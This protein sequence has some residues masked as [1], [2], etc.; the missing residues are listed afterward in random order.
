[1]CCHFGDVNSC[2]SSNGRRVSRGTSGVLT[3]RLIY[4]AFRLAFNWTSS[5]TMTLTLAASWLHLGPLTS[6]C[7]Q[8]CKSLRRQCLLYMSRT[9]Y[10]S[11]LIANEFSM[12]SD[13]KIQGTDLGLD[14][15]D[16]AV[17]ALSPKASA[18]SPS[19]APYSV[20][21]QTQKRWIIA[22][23]ALAGWFSSL[24]SF[25]YFPAI[26]SIATD[27]GESIERINLTVTAYLIMSGLF[28]SIVADAADTM[29]R[30]PVFIVT[31][32]VYVAANIG[33]ALQTS[34]GLLF[35]LR[36]AQSA[37]ISGSYAVTYGVIGDVFTPSERGG[38]SGLVSFA[39]NTPPSI[40]PVISGLLLHRWGWRAIFWFL[41]AISP[42]C[43]LAIVFLLPETSR[44]IVDDGTVPPH[45]L[46]L[47][48]RPILPFLTPPLAR[49]SL[50]LRRA[51]AATRLP[52]RFR[53]PNP[54]TALIL[55]KAPGT[56][57]VIGSAGIWYTI[58][59]CL[60]ASLSSLF[61]E[62]Y[63]VSGLI[64]GVSYLPFGIACAIS[65]YCSG[66]HE[67]TLLS[68]L[69]LLTS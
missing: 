6:S 36:M 47:L 1:M 53:I 59:S 32:A 17:V 4:A 12:A 49:Q 56:A 64:S 29:G 33:L 35:F 65:A 9:P 55:L 69:S 28:P 16:K 13:E 14:P 31:L 68:K 5:C 57:I 66:R 27:L 24:S 26:P 45:G 41:S 60:Q 39:L 25:I 50:D 51:V 58:Y 21:T 10:C 40:G 43:L 48:S 30:R 42:C 18:S 34:F 7:P 15:A 67:F 37:G 61:T 62:I 20:F 11:I 52:R 19:D 8:H 38:Y 54:F 22:L 44:Q 23:V 63:Q 2:C 46:G 3:F